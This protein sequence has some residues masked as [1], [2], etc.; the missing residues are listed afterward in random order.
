MIKVIKSDFLFAE[1]KQKFYIRTPKTNAQVAE[2]TKE[3]PPLR[4]EKQMKE[5][6]LVL[7]FL[8]QRKMPRWRNW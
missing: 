4:C 1:I 7:Q 8:G 5:I 2:P 6:L 3:L